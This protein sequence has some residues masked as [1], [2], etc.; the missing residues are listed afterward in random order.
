MRN[1]DFIRWPYHSIYLYKIWPQWKKILQNGLFWMHNHHSCSPST[2]LG[3]FKWKW[4]LARIVVCNQQEQWLIRSN[5]RRKE[6]QMKCQVF[7][8]WKSSWG[9][10]PSGFALKESIWPQ[11][12]KLTAFRFFLGID[13][14]YFPS[15]SRV[16]M[17]HLWLHPTTISGAR[18]LLESKRST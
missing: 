9:S 11:S 10:Q 4:Q 6:K 3:S 1:F 2:A 5:K 13:H 16:F 15:S 8:L 7:N 17:E 12:A 14:W 18:M